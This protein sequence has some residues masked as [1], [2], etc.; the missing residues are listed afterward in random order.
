MEIVSK[1]NTSLGE[2]GVV[3]CFLQ[4]EN[5]IP[6]HEFSYELCSEKESRNICTQHVSCVNQ[7]LYKLEV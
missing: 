2:D 3:I 5:L 7:M 1:L 4:Y 6:A